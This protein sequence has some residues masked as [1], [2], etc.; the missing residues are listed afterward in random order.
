MNV[1]STMEGV[2]ITV[3]ILTVVSTVLVVMDTFW[4]KII[5]VVLVCD[6]SRAKVY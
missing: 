1:S 6:A 2:T 3:L 5:P 4:K